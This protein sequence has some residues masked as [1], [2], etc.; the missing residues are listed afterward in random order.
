MY[1][2]NH[3]IFSGEHVAQKCYVENCTFYVSNMLERVIFGM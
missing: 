2:D 3:N 1:Y